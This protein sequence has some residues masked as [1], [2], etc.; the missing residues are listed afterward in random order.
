[1][2]GTDLTRK[3]SVEG[4]PVDKIL[5]DTGCS[6]TLVHQELV[7][8]SRLLEGEAMVIHCAHG[9]TVLY[10]VALL[11]VVVS[12]RTMEVRAAVSATC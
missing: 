4:R 11:Q 10:P 3:G 9:D 6:K 7:P 5:L 12:M 1:M 8:R 2:T